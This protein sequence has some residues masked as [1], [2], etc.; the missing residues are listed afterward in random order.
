MFCQLVEWFCV[1][2]LS[3]FA[4]YSYSERIATSC[5]SVLK[6]KTLA[7]LDRRGLLEDKT[8]AILDKEP[9]KTIIILVSVTEWCLFA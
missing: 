4:S 5:R 7:I 3:K 6:D 8:L 1:T 2:R 9:V